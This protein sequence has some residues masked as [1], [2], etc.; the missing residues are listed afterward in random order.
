MNENWHRHENSHN[1]N[2]HGR[3][4]AA[5]ALDLDELTRPDAQRPRRVAVIGGAGYVGSVLVRRLLDSGY[6]VNVLDALMYGDEGIRDLYGR[7]GFTV[8]QGDLRDHEAVS[9]AVADA[10]AVAHLGGLVGDPACELDE[11]LTLEVNLDATRMIGQAARASGVRRFVFASTCSVYGASSE[12]LDEHSATSPVSL[13]ARSKLVS[14]RLLNELRDEDFAPVIL[15]FGTLYGLAPRPRFDLVVNLLTAKAVEENSITIFGGDQWRPFLHVSDAAAAILRCLEAP[16]YLVEGQVFNV[17]SDE[18]NH[19]VADL[20]AL[21]QELVPEVHV[22]YDLTEVDPA[23]YRVAFTKIRELLDFTPQRTLAEGMAEIKAAIERGEIGDYRAR[24]YNNKRALS[25]Q[26]EH[27]RETTFA[28]MD[29][30][31]TSS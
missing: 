29:A 8:I 7:P 4:S 5:G 31:G 22:T 20:G 6:E 23:D 30:T 25:P 15:R 24:R 10:D 9:R 18:Q 28:E 1:H 21:I 3:L 12:I 2:G 26:V 19:P 13:Y 27:L 14:E 11:T 17:G 16:R